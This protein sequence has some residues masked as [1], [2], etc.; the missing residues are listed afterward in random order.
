MQC[1]GRTPQYTKTNL[2]E[3]QPLP[4]LSC[5]VQ[6][7]NFSDMRRN[8]FFGYLIAEVTVIILVMVFF[9]FISDRQ[10]AATLAGILFVGLP[11]LMMILEYRRAGFK[12][13]VWFLAVLQFWIVFALPILGLRIFNWGVPFEELSFLGFPGPVLH[14]WSSKSY[15]IMMFFTAW[16]WFRVWRQ[17]KKAIA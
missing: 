17:N 11:L 14:K 1:E 3:F 8:A 10:I 15:M 13:G 12:E 7:T 16:S 6:W 2:G 5:L 4:A 9:K